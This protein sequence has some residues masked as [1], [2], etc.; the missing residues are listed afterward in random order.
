M[1]TMGGKGYVKDG[2]CEQLYRDGRITMIYEGT[3]GIQAL[4]LIGRKIAKDGGQSLIKL[5]DTLDIPK[6]I[7]KKIDSA[8]QVLLEN[9]MNPNYIAAMAPSYLNLLAIGIQSGLIM[10]EYYSDIREFY[11]DYVTPEM[12]MYLA[13]IQAGLST[14]MD[15]PEY[16]QRLGEGRE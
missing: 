5:L 1:Q 8:N 6:P 10:D 13:R 4:D 9:A 7:R 11:L 3:N 2:L 16:N 15:H 14:M 12:D